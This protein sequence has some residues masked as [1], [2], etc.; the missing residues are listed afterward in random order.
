MLNPAAFGCVLDGG[1]V[2]TCSLADSA[3]ASSCQAVAEEFSASKGAKV[4]RSG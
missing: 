3:S 4:P 1:A 2:T